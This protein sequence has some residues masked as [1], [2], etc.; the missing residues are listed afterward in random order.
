VIERPKHRLKTAQRCVLREILETIPLHDAAHGFTRSRSAVTHARLHTNR[1][2]VVR[3]D[4]RDFFASVSAGRVFGIFRAAGYP[5]SL[6]HCLAALCTN[7]VSRRFWHTLPR[8]TD[9]RTIPLHHRLG[10]QLAV[11]HLPQGAPTSPALANLAAYGLDRRLSGL[12]AKLGATYSRYADDLVFSGDRGLVRAAPSL[13]ARITHIAR[14]EG[15]TV[16]ESKST[17]AT[18]AARQRVCGVVVNE[19]P[20]VERDE[21]DLLKATLHNAARD[22]PASQ[23]RTGVSDF[24]AHLLGRIAWVASLNPSRGER[25]L[26]VFRRIDWSP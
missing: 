21:Y 6:S 25:L 26:A 17:L 3:V 18:R 9:S 10:R 23:N 15:F 14:E 7:V 2:V 4:L 22:G 13:R 19:H 16:N 1:A 12:A 8:P 5:E 11:P 20:N 24:R